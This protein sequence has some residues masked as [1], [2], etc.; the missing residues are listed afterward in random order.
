V[1]RLRA[2]Y[3]VL[4]GYSIGGDEKEQG[5]GSHISCPLC[6]NKP[7]AF[8]GRNDSIDSLKQEVMEMKDYVSKYPTSSA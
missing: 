3:Y 2:S 6:V 7:N 1:S 4:C 8:G 5:F